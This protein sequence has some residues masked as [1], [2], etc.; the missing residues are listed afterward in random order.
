MEAQACETIPVASP[1]WALRSNIMNGILI[2]GDVKEELTISRFAGEIVRI[3]KS[4]ELRKQLTSKMSEAALIRFNWERYVDQ[5]EGWIFQP[6]VRFF[7]S[8][9]AFQHKY[10]YGKILNVGCDTDASDFHSTRNA[11]NLDIQQHGNAHVDIIADIRS[12]TVRNTIQN[13][14][15][16]VIVGDLLEHMYHEDAIRTL[17]NASY[18]LKDNNSLLII[19]C[20]ED[21]RTPEEQNPTLTLNTSYKGGVSHFHRLVS[22]EELESII[23]RSGLQILGIQQID[24]THFKSWGVLCRLS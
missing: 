18:G 23:A 19:T 24:C 10:A 7:S 22:L 12:N 14:Y 20:P 21:P 17:T 5:W 1:V 15:D 2:E 16:T 8:Q 11:I 4:A 6:N 13:Q 9:Y 3:C